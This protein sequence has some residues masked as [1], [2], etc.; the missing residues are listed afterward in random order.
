MFLHYFLNPESFVAVGQMLSKYDSERQKTQK[1]KLDLRIASHNEESL[2]CLRNLHG[3][4]SLTWAKV[5]GNLD[6]LSPNLIAS[7]AHVDFS[8]S[9]DFSGLAFVSTLPKLRVL[10]LNC[11]RKVCNED[12]RNL[13]GNACLEMLELLRCRVDDEG[14]SH[15][16]SLPALRK[17]Q[18]MSTKVTEIGIR[19]L[20]RGLT[21]L[22]IIQAPVKIDDPQSWEHLRQLESLEIGPDVEDDDFRYLSCLTKLQRLV[23]HGNRDLT[24]SGLSYLA[25]LP[26]LVDFTYNGNMLE[27]SN[28]AFLRGLRKLSVVLSTLLDSNIEVVRL[29]PE[30][31]ALDLLYCSNLTDRVFETFEQCPLLQQVDLSGSGVTA[32]AIATFKA[33]WRLIFR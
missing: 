28:L 14:M 32:A 13:I 29:L 33:R 3:V 21:H 9:D 11:C 15:L 7:L 25:N 24:G 16:A 30:L 5:A 27:F 6:F 18:L 19:R 1:L 2:Q 31:R 12:L 10:K 26:Y 23:L 22:G 4:E 20:P 8:M 17:I